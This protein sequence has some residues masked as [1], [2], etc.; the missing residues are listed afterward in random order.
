MMEPVILCIETSTAVCSVA[1]GRGR[2]VI[3]KEENHDGQSHAVQLGIFLDKALQEL[4]SRGESLSAVAVSSG[5]G[6]Y[7]GLRIGVSMAKGVC[8]ARQIPLI[9]VP[10]LQVTAAQ[11][12][13]DADTLL[14]PMTDARRMEVYT[15]VFDNLLKPVSETQ[16]LIIDAASLSDLPQGKKVFIF[17]DGAAKASKVIS[18]EGVTLLADLYPRA[19]D[20]V[21][22]ALD[23]YNAK[24]F[25][26]VAYFEPFYLKEFQATVPHKLNDLIHHD[27]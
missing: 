16:A 12:H 20:M 4:E 6:S 25:E 19:E 7:T 13:A 22:L 18:R 24:R 10:S 27:N 9:A 14:C 2:E 3:F 5:P 11:V 26:D 17:G 23:A 1:L 8:Y 15:A 21:P